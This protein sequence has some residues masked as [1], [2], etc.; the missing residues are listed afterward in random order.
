MITYDGND[1]HDRRGHFVCS[2]G[3][4]W[5][6]YHYLQLKLTRWFDRLSIR[7]GHNIARP[8]KNLAGKKFPVCMNCSILGPLVPTRGPFFYL[9]V[10]GR[11]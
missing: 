6:V 2:N 8:R 9:V 4:L 11:R 10:L 7:T 3:D 1:A 5:F